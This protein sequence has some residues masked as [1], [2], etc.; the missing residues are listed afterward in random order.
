MFQGCEQATAIKPV[1]KNALPPP[2]INSTTTPII[3]R[4]YQQ[5]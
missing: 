5:N 1:C 4:E 3:V 2:E